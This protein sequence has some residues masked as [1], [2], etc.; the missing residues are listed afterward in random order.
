MGNKLTKSEI[1]ELYNPPKI[2]YKYR[3]L[4][5]SIELQNERT[6]EILQK[7][8]M[9]GSDYKSLNDPMEGFYRINENQERTLID[10]LKKDKKELRICSL[11][12]SNNN[13]LL[14]G[15]YANGNKG[16]AIGV[17]SF[18]AKKDLIKVTYGNQI[19]FFDDINVL[20]ANQ[21]LCYKTTPWKYEKEWRVI[22]N[23]LFIKVKIDHIILGMAISPEDKIEIIDIVSNKNNLIEI[24]NQR[25]KIYQQTREFNFRE[26]PPL[27]R[28]SN[29]FEEQTLVQ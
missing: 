27:R 16:I 6:F 21:I 8:E 12:K 17:R 26:L 9:Y 22:T 28:E 5:S 1:L 10:Q 11:S 13:P 14:W 18:F 24:P 19:P 25:I 20:S 2:L 23:N 15:H 7:S 3:V 4:G 29:T